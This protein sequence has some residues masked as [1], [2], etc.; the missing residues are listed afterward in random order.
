MQLLA[1]ALG[2][3]FPGRHP[4]NW[5]PVCEQILVH[6]WAARS[7]AEDDP[8]DHEADP[9]ATALR[10]IGG[11]DSA[12]RAAHFRAAGLTERQ[13]ARRLRIRPAK[14][15]TWFELCDRLRGDAAVGELAF[16]APAGSGAR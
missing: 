16:D 3:Q 7:T 10:G 1:L 15:R 9:R 5:R 2:A 8:T 13:I 4:H 14:V 12:A 6:A 11:E